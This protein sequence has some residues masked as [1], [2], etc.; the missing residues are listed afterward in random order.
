MTNKQLIKKLE[1]ACVVCRDCGLKYGVYS[2]GCSSVWEG[3]CNVCGETKPVTETRDYGYLMTGIRKLLKEDVKEQS[4]EVAEYMLTQEPTVTNHPITPPPEMVEEWT[5]MLEYHP[6]EKVL[7]EVARWGADAELEACLE[8]ISGQDWTWTKAQ[9][10]A[11]RRPKPPTLKE[12]ALDALEL[13]I[14]FIES[15]NKRAEGETIR[16]AL[17]ALP[18]D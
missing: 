14:P 9:L 8:W 18:N 10:R 13:F 7:S 1:N 5:S 3:V 17:E 11:A 2:V 12:Q 15:E 4:N 16:R 6:D